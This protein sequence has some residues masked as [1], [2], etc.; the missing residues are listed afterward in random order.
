MRLK[1]DF[2]VHKGVNGAI[3]L[4]SGEEAK[5]FRGIVKLNKTAEEI[6][7][8]LKEETS[9]EEILER[10]VREYPSTPKET[11]SSDIDNVLRQLEAIHALV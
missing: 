1:S 5:S 6:L 3:L 10:F 8:C 11:L 7:D 4:A 9:K 2:V